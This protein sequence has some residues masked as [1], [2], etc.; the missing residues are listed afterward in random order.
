MDANSD[1]LWVYITTS[2]EAEAREIGKML[3]TERLAACVNIIPN[4]Y[5]IYHWE[6]KVVEENESILIAKTT[7]SLLASL[8]D[9]T[10]SLHS[11]SIPCIVAL[12]VQ[13]GNPPFLKWI[14]DET[15]P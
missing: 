5:S 3:V 6:K 1:I 4:V 9:R 7:K 14:V 8:T 12:P 2:N 13:G 11:Y 15:N 10:I